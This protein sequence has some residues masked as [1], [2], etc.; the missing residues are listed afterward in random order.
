MKNENEAHAVETEKQ[1]FNLGKEILQIIILIV[2]AVFA[3]RLIN[4]FVGQRTEVS[5]PS[6]YD[7]LEDGDNRWGNKM[8]YH[9][10]DPERFDIVIFP[11]E[12]EM[13][14]SEYFIKRIIGL[15]GEKVRI[16]EN[17]TIYIN[18]EPLEENYGYEVI[19]ADMI[20]RAKNNVVLGQMSI[21]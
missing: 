13:T 4:I 14:D 1:A 19:D 2:L 15:P 8:A 6:M 5:G 3:A 9:F 17:G 21:L 7:T 11:H 20:E 16:D 10:Q 12:D 18:D